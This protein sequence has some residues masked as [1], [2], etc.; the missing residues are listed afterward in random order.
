MLSRKRLH[1][2]HVLTINTICERDAPTKYR[3]WF[4][5]DHVVVDNTHD[6]SQVYPPS[7]S[8]SELSADFIAPVLE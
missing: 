6:S 7:T 5:G 1:D 4:F 3:L 2:L 8:N